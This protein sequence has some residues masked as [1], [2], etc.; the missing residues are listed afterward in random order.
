MPRMPEATIRAAGFP[1]MKRARFF[2][3]VLVAAAAWSAQGGACAQPAA[4]ASAPPAA[5]LPVY[6]VEIRIGPAWDV[7]KKPHEQTHFREHSANLKRLRD[8]GSLVLGARYGDKGLVL[9]HAA[10]EADAHAMMQQDPAIQQRVFVYE[11][12]EFSVF[13]GGSM[14]PRPRGRP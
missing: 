1:A 9:L 6:A 7:A 3:P 12:H 13:Y 2:L 4:A 10:S 14:Q 8:Q 5:Q 11:L